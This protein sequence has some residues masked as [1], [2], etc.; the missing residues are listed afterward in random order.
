MSKKTYLGLFIGVIILISALSTAGCIGT[1]PEQTYSA[2]NIISE[3]TQIVYGQSVN[4]TAE[5]AENL[6]LNWL[7][8]SDPSLGS[9][10]KI[11][12]NNYRF[13][14]ASE[15]GTVT[16]TVVAPN[17]GLR[18]EPN[19]DLKSEIEIEI[20][21]PPTL[22]VEILSDSTIEIEE[23]YYYNLSYKNDGSV[24]LDSVSLVDKNGN[25]AEGLDTSR[26]TIRI[27]EP[28]IYTL[29][30]AYHDFLGNP[31]K[32]T[33]TFFATTIVEAIL[34]PQEE[35]ELKSF[36]P[37]DILGTENFLKENLGI[38]ISLKKVLQD[39]KVVTGSKD[40]YVAFLFVRDL[41]QPRVWF[42]TGVNAFDFYPKDKFKVVT[43][44]SSDGSL[45]T[46]A[47]GYSEY[48]E[49]ISCVAAFPSI[50][51]YFLELNG[52]KPNIYFGDDSSSSGG[53]SSPVVPSGSGPSPKPL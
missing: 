7:N 14:A 1:E 6:S 21:A 25:V 41:Y 18:N 26:Q 22:I 17:T 39:G 51:G 8:L 49:Q 15:S 48:T 40:S 46:V 33:E 44:K 3:Q 20:F 16:I 29:V 45:W 2:I 28:G 13:T 23:D 34:S 50:D 19:T 35:I 12:D 52:L 4:I 5:Q 38:D 43:A 11:S 30:V 36:A 31:L 53:G 32:E 37:M 10:E 42:M 47:V 9:F 24:Y 27:K